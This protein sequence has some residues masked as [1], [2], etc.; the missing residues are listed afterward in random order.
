MKT[1][2]CT[3]QSFYDVITKSVRNVTMSDV[4]ARLILHILFLENSKSVALILTCPG[5]V[6][7]GSG[8]WGGNCTAQ[9]FQQTKDESNQ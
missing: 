7:G 9:N 4:L 3:I 2:T 8:V 6:C 5:C 1:N